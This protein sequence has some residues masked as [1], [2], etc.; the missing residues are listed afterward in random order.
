MRVLIAAAW[1]AATLWGCGRSG[2]APLSY[3]PPGSTITTSRPIEIQSR[4]EWDLGGVG[5]SN[6]Y[7]GARLSGIESAND[8]LLMGQ[9]S[10]E[11]APINNSAWFGFKIWSEASRSVW[12]SLTYTDGEHRYVPKL[13]LDGAS[14]TPI[15]QGDYRLDSTQSNSALFRLDLSKDTLWVSAQERLTSVELDDWAADLA[16]EHDDVERKDV[17]TSTYGAPLRMLDV[18]AGEDE[19]VLIISRQHPPEVTGTHGLLHFVDRLTAGDPLAT[20]FR[21]RYRTLVVPLMNPDGVDDGHWRHNAGGVDL[22]RDWLNFNQ[23]ETRGVSEYF[24][25]RVG[26]GTVRFAIDFHSTQED[27]F[28]TTSRELQTNT[29]GLIDDWLADIAAALPDYHVRDQASGVDSPVSKAWFYKTFSA[30]SL[31]YEVGDEEDR[32]QIRSVAEAGAES[33]MRRL[34]DVPRN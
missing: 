7:P 16:R 28:Y 30:T 29:P 12:I 21:S 20:E 25:R 32:A 4:K 15:D 31:T 1:A 2:D 10:P 9:I 23:P 34:L 17:A 5:V 33:M 13:S 11:N 24:V 18:G 26:Q 19:F 22:N 3:D 8:T 27:V 14:W 6:R